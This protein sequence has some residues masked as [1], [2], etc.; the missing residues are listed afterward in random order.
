MPC[1]D[2]MKESPPQCRWR[3]ASYFTFGRSTTRWDGA[4]DIFE[5]VHPPPAFSGALYA[6]EGWRLIR[7]VRRGRPGSRGRDLRAARR[8]LFARPP[9]IPFCL[10]PLPPTEG[11]PAS[12]RS[13]GSLFTIVRPDGGSGAFFG[14]AGE[15]MAGRFVEGVLYAIIVRDFFVPFNMRR[16][17]FSARIVK[18]LTF[19]WVLRG[20]H[21]RVLRLKVVEA[22]PFPL[23]T[24]SME[25]SSLQR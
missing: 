7:N 23:E 6:P 15:T 4:Y 9:P 21:N 3:P 14:D 12:P 22:W 16:L 8:A 13:P 18:K 24:C 11:A 20:A 1:Q 19:E 2:S 5:S 17:L 10:S 25:Y